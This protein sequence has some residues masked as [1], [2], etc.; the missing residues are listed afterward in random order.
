MT[1]EFV[2]NLR[3]QLKNGKIDVRE[4]VPVSAKKPPSD[5][6]SFKS[7]ASSKSGKPSGKTGERYLPKAA[8][9]A[10]ARLLD[11]L[12]GSVVRRLVIAVLLFAGARALLKGLGVWP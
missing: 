8:R 10:L 9:E 4:I 7:S 2:L 11:V 1:L 5:A 6:E 3:D 12:K